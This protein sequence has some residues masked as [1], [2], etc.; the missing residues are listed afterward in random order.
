M[1]LEYHFLIIYY[2]KCPCCFPD[3]NINATERNVYFALIYSLIL[4]I[5]ITFK[6]ILLNVSKMVNPLSTLPVLRFRYVLEQP[7]YLDLGNIRLLL[8]RKH[9]K[10]NNKISREG[11]L[12]Y[13]TVS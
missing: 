9:K 2:H 4:Y 5:R 7:C 12:P 11:K 1:G 3:C 8:R 13:P 6:P 10:G